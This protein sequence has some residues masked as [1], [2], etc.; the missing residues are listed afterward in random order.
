MGKKSVPIAALNVPRK[1]DLM[2]KDNDIDV[3]PAAGSF[4]AIIAGSGKKT[5]CGSNMF[6]KDR[7]SHN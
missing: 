4:N 5:L 2:M 6:I 7:R 3:W 1:R